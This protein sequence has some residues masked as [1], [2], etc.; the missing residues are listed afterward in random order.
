[1]MRV[2]ERAPSW[3]IRHFSLA[4]PAGDRQYDVPALLRR[5]AD[6]LEELGPVEVQDVVFR[7]E[8]DGGGEERPSMTVY[9]HPTVTFDQVRDLFVPFV[10]DASRTA[11]VDFV[12]EDAGTDEGSL[13]VLVKTDGTGDGFAFDRQGR[14]DDSALRALE[15]FDVLQETVHEFR[16]RQGLFGPWPACPVE[17]HTHKLE[18]SWETETSTA[19][20]SCPEGERLAP[21]GELDTA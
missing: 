16:A 11:D 2:T 10:A 7:M 14:G 17:G 21:I 3:T 9:F 12:V 5:V 1:M 15:C 18:T 19:W 13:F 4:N 20:W 8:I 6:T